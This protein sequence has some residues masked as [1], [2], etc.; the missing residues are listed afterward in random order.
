MPMTTNEPQ[1]EEEAEEE[2]WTYLLEELLP[3]VDKDTFVEEV[4]DSLKGRF[5]RVAA[6]E[7]GR[8]LVALL[9]ILDAWSIDRAEGIHLER[10][11]ADY[12]VYPRVDNRTGQT[13]SSDALRERLRMELFKQN[14]EAT[15]P[16]I[17][18]LIW[19]M[20]HWLGARIS[21]PEDEQD[22]KPYL[23]GLTRPHIK[24]L[25]NPHTGDRPIEERDLYVWENEIPMMEVDAASDPDLRTYK[26][27]N[28]AVVVEIPWDAIWATFRW[29][30]FMVLPDSHPEH[31]KASH[32]VREGGAR[33]RYADYPLYELV[34]F[35]QM[36]KAAG[37][38][39]ILRGINGFQIHDQ[40]TG[41]P[42]ADQ[43]LADHHGTGGSRIAGDLEAFL[44]KVRC[45]NDA[46]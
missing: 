22:Y 8:A 42:I 19:W 10:I 26:D 38:Q 6:G 27:L 36:V 37:V 34:Q 21:T 5:L 20:L 18:K 12:D 2:L 40:A 24:P 4:R 33:I 23:M 25:P 31:G 44:Q 11:A 3:H 1:I 16:H 17:R 13:E 32:Q 45:D 7:F 15:V 28:A 29:D 39:M 41:G 9:A 35:A 43:S 46:P 14:S 30:A